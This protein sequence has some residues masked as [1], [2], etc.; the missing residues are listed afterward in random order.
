MRCKYKSFGCYYESIRS[1]PPSGSS[2]I[3]VWK[4]VYCEKVDFFSLWGYP[5]LLFVFFSFTY[6]R[7]L[8]PNSEF[9]SF[10]SSS[11]LLCLFLPFLFFQRSIPPSVPLPLILSFSHTH[12]LFSHVYPHP[13]V[14]QSCAQCHVAAMVFAQR[15]SASVRRVGL[16]LHATREHAILAVKNMASATMGP[17][18]A[19]RAGRESTVTL[20]SCVLVHVEWFNYSFWYF[21]QHDL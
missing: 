8:T 21:D 3:R 4:I 13:P 1:S 6:I 5:L 12:T 7:W 18:S 17:A 20:V 11:C 19:S 10:F 14:W 9:L 15:A 16:A 2:A